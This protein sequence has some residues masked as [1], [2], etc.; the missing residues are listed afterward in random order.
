MEVY[1]DHAEP[2]ILVCRESMEHKD[3]WLVSW[4]APEGVTELIVLMVCVADLHAQCPPPVP[5]VKKGKIQVACLG[6]MA[7][8][9]TLVLSRDPT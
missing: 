6:D 5:R 9:G 7:L 1:L 4:P 3:G 2:H 8:G